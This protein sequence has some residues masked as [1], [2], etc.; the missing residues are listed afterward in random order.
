MA[1]GFTLKQQGP[2]CQ[3]SSRKTDLGVCPRAA[4]QHFT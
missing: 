3:A 4:E 2:L 1:W